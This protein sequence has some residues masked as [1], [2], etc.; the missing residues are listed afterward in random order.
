MRRLALLIVTGALLTGCGSKQAAVTT[1]PTSHPAPTKT[2][3]PVR[4]HH[5]IDAVLV[6]VIDGIPVPK[7]IDFGVTKATGE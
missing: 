5:R 1:A 3:A 2:V 7:V 6:T 4:L